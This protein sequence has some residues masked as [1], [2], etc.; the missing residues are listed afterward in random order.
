MSPSRLSVAF[1][2]QAGP[3][4]ENVQRALLPVLLRIAHRAK[5]CTTCFTILH[6]LSS[7]LVT[8]LTRVLHTSYISFTCALA[9]TGDKITEGNKTLTVITIKTNDFGNSVISPADSLMSKIKRNTSFH[10]RQT[11]ID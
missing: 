2:G 10:L 4:T 1:F 8:I 5:A 6:L 3:R 7:R 9:L 11:N